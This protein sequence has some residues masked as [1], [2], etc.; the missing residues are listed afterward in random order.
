MKLKGISCAV[1]K[2][3]VAAE[4]FCDRFGQ[5]DIEKIVRNSGVTSRRVS[6]DGATSSD[7]CAV[8]A[9]KLLDDLQWD[10]DSV[11]L[12]VF[13]SQ[14]PDYV[15]PPTSY[16]LHK[17]L[18]MPETCM[19]F[20]IN[21][22]CSGF[23]HGLIVMRSL[24]VT[25]SIRRGL[26][27]CGDTLTK[28]AN[29]LDRATAL[30]FGDAGAAAAVEND[31][32]DQ[33]KAAVWG[34]EGAGYEYLIVPAGGFRDPWKPEY[35]E[36]TEDADGNFRRP[37]DL[38]MDG[39]Q[40]FNFTIRRVPQM[41]KEVTEK[42]GWT[43]DDVDFFLF[44]QANKFIIDYLRRKL[45]VAEDKLP[46]CLEEF[47]NTSCA[48]I[49]LTMVSRVGGVLTDPRKLVLIGFGVGLS[50]SAVAMQTENIRVLPL[51]EV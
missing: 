14:T 48:S 43:A 19:T 26:L 7:L 29:P 32:P 44:H 46:T 24:M 1:P 9:R 8:A 45:K 20:D 16:R 31:G 27:L 35:L 39:A 10:P 23:T 38:K 36:T 6:P 4:S 15:L 12:L 50:W 40:V 49:P 42:A 41:V 21:L 3:I 34:S 18:D 5:E 22:G 51:L 37:T 25:E 30:L 13:V 11:G 47:G 28:I 33:I 2:A 17:E